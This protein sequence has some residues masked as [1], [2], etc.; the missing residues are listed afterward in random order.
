MNPFL[1]N[2]RVEIGGYCIVQD[3][4][5]LNDRVEK[6]CTVQIPCLLNDRVEIG[7]CTVKDSMF[8]K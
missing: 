4:C 7:G 6:G 1:L 8:T 3:P 2:D 5:L